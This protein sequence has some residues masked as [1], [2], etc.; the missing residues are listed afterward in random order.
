M[1]TKIEDLEV[2]LSYFYRDA[3][4]INWCLCKVIATYED[5]VWLHN[6]YTGSMPI[7]HFNRIKMQGNH[8]LE[9]TV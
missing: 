8:Q 1:I 6:F 2:G 4:G 9:L 7:K 5:K 3:G